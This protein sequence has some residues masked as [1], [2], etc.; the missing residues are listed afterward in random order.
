MQSDLRSSSVEGAF[1]DSLFDFEARPGRYAIARREP[2]VLFERTY[3]VLTLACGRALGGIDLEPATAAAAHKAARFFVRSVLLRPGS[4]PYTVLGVTRDAPPS[5]L[6]DHYRLLMRL[7]HPDFLE[8][9]ERSWPVDAATRINQAYDA[10]SAPDRRREIDQAVLKAAFSDPAVA[11]PLLRRPATRPNRARARTSG[12]RAALVASMVSAARK[13]ATALVDRAQHFSFTRAYLPMWSAAF[14][15]AGLGIVLLWLWSAADSREI[16]VGPPPEAV[17]RVERTPVRQSQLV[18]SAADSERAA[19]PVELAQTEIPAATFPP[20]SS[21]PAI[22][23]ERASAAVASREP[24]PSTVAFPVTRVEPIASPL[25]KIDTTVDRFPAPVDLPVQPPAAAPIA[26]SPQQTVQ[27]VAVAVAAPSL[28]STVPVITSP[29]A[30]AAPRI[31]MADVQSALT[32]VV[33]AIQSGRGED[34]LQWLDRSARRSDA[35]TGFVQ[36]YNRMRS[37]AKVIGVGQVS[38]RGI[39]L[40]DQFVV[41][42]TVQLFVQDENQ[43]TIAREFKMKAHFISRDG[44][45]ILTQLS[46]ADQR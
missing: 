9:N 46:A 23:V 39:S 25:L 12:R 3:E 4:D 43:R 1:F 15:V 44:N 11:S 45:P 29:I 28:V 37:G 19:V 10:L 2:R 5:V 40:S 22:A 31:G 26:P 24:V 7:T 38:F 13:G 18:A 30:P 20:A 6:R 32:S 33:G 42:G 34:A 16:T 41:D 27:T 35:A 21:K 14:G 8:A 17:A 36:A